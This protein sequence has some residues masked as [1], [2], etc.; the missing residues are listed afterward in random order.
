M[1]QHLFE[2]HEPVDLYVEIGKGTVDI[3]ATETSESRVEIS[4]RD[5]D[6]VAGVDLA[7]PGLDPARADRAG[8]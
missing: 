5:A 7:R 6:E 1:T 2:T 3:N 8:H 4:G